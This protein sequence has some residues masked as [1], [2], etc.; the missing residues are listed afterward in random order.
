MCFSA[1][2]S[3]IA[4]GS[5]TAVG[6]V[7]VKRAANNRSELLFAAI[8][9]FF[10]VQQLTEGALWL[11][12]YYDAVQLKT[13]TTYLFTLFSHVLW[14]VYMPFAVWAMEPELRRRKTMLGFCLI[15]VA[16]GVYLF[17]LMVTLPLTA[18][19]KEHIIYVSPHFYKG[20]VMMLY[21]A[22]TCIVTFF[23]SHLLVRVFGFM[24][25]LL[26]FVALW[27]HVEAFFSIWCFFAAI[28]S[29]I[30]YSR[31]NGANTGK[32]KKE[33]LSGS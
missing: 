4:G 18:V 30:I 31:F 23:S 32:F 13:V 12:F 28:L 21:I 17:V 14:P 6:A 3:F 1:T 22:A 26:F 8:P 15:G 11:S 19:L 16:V 24:A 5:L 10:G 7:T 2:A 20:P 29:L 33:V 25:L 9:L 27:F